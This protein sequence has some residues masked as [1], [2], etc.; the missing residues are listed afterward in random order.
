MILMKSFF[1]Q[2]FIILAINHQILSA[3]FLSNRSLQNQQE[4]ILSESNYGDCYD[5]TTDN[6][7]E[8]KWTLFQIPSKS[9]IFYPDCVG[10]CGQFGSIL[11]PFSSSNGLQRLIQ[12]SKPH[13]KVTIEAAFVQIDGW[14][15]G[16][17]F[18]MI[19]DGQIVYT[20]EYYGADIL[21]VNQCDVVLNGIQDHMQALKVT[22]PHSSNTINIS[23]YTIDSNSEL[24][25]MWGLKNFTVLT[26]I[27]EPGVNS[28]QDISPL[29]YIL[30]TQ[31]FNQPMIKPIIQIQFNRPLTSGI[32]NSDISIQIDQV[33]SQLYNYTVSQID[34]QYQTFY[35]NF[36][37]M[38]FSTY[39]GQ[40]MTITILKQVKDQNG[41]ALQQQSV[42][43]IMPSYYNYPI[44]DIN[45]ISTVKKITQGFATTIVVSTAILTFG[46]DKFNWLFYS[47]DIGQILYLSTF[48]NVKFP[49]NVEQ[50]LFDG[51]S[52]FHLQGL[53]EIFKQI[54][55]NSTIQQQQPYFQRFQDLGIKS[56][57]LLNAGNLV[58]FIIVFLIIFS[59][60]QLLSSFNLIKNQRFKSSLQ[61]Y[62]EKKVKWRLFFS[63]AYFLYA[64]IL[65]AALIQ[66]FTWSANSF[67]EI[68]SY[69]LSFI[70]ILFGMLMPLGMYRL[71]S[72]NMAKVLDNS[73]DK[74]FTQKNGIAWQDLKK[75]EKNGSKKTIFFHF[76]LLLRRSFYA[77]I[78]VFFQFNANLQ[79]ALLNICNVSIIFVVIF[80]MPFTKRRSNYKIIITEFVLVCEYMVIQSYQN[81]QENEQSRISRGWIVA[82][83]TVFI[84]FLQIFFLL[85]DVFEPVVSYLK[86]FYIK[87]Q[88]AKLQEAP[89][90]VDLEKQKLKVAEEDEEQVKIKQ[91]N[92]LNDS[93][94]EKHQNQ[95]VKVPINQSEIAQNNVS[96]PQILNRSSFKRTSEFSNSKLQQSK[97]FI[98]TVAKSESQLKIPAL[99][100]TDGV[101][102]QVS[103]NL[104]SSPPS[105]ANQSE[106]LVSSQKYFGSNRSIKLKNA[107]LPASSTLPSNINSNPHNNHQVLNTSNNN[108]SINQFD[109]NLEIVLKN[110]NIENIKRTDTQQEQ[111][112]NQIKNTPK[113]ILKHQQSNNSVN[114]TSFQQLDGSYYMPQIQNYDQISTKISN[115]Q[116]IA[117]TFNNSNL[118]IQQKLS[119]ED[120]NSLNK[121]NSPH[122][123]SL[124]FQGFKIKSDSEIPQVNRRVSR[125]LSLKVQQQFISPDTY[126][127]NATEETE[128]EQDD[129]STLK[130]HFFSK[131]VRSNQTIQEQPGEENG[132]I[133]GQSQVQI[134]SINESPI[135]IASLQQKKIFPLLRNFPRHQSR[136]I[137]REFT[138]IE[139]ENE[140]SNQNSNSIIIHDGI[141]SRDIQYTGELTNKSKIAQEVIKKF[142]FPSSDENS[143]VN[144]ENESPRQAF[145]R[146]N[147]RKK[148]QFAKYNSENSIQD[149]ATQVGITPQQQSQTEIGEQKTNQI[150]QQEVKEERQDHLSGIQQDVSIQSAQDNPTKLQAN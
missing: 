144:N 99:K 111:N 79:I 74:T 42:Q 104:L 101:I 146:L 133:M 118:F 91:S 36:D 82:F 38:N 108:V 89:V 52:I 73:L 29:K 97:L 106:L 102:P 134:R 51:C 18:V 7:Y 80:Q 50:V 24:V 54:I 5:F 136:I 109:Q 96:T 25:N 90:D 113:K 119:Y 26:D 93:N 6:L 149:D 4:V 87:L 34:N 64:Q 28:C 56:L 117:E 75:P 20:W 131:M 58:V 49:Q 47:T 127:R 83:A 138:N 8:N 21:D 92:L 132:S 135:D 30:N 63:L 66:I 86:V 100:Q 43:S 77:C 123:S 88:E 85:I 110:D 150:E 62:L 37:Q 124:S 121:S 41:M 22:V 78:V 95:K 65:F 141:S 67:S 40:L 1:H 98:G 17:Q 112:N 76:F 16:Q 103:L 122:K 23:V 10:K 137:Q 55:S 120:D 147:D 70:S 126:K 68:I 45:M 60:I 13:T 12:I 39:Y 53:T 46:F 9:I 107:Q 57:F 105:L 32:L 59:I 116:T 69:I 14:S 27:C 15:V 31:S 3:Q 145:T 143:Q 11:G 2:I 19:I 129:Q 128:E 114:S 115:R 139:E 140:E 61:F 48:I 35:I 148:S 94:H 72:K 142:G 33:D 125:N 84:V 44:S 81:E 71:I 130:P